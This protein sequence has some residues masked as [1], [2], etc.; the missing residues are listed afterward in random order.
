MIHGKLYPSREKSD[1]FRILTAENSQ[2]RLLTSK[3]NSP[4]KID[5]KLKTQLSAST[6]AR[7]K[8]LRETLKI[9]EQNKLNRVRQKIRIIDYSCGEDSQDF[10]FKRPLK[11]KSH[12]AK[13]PKSK[14]SPVKRTSSAGRLICRNPSENTIKAVDERYENILM[15][16]TTEEHRL[17]KFM[18]NQGLLTTAGT[19]NQKFFER[20]VNIIQEG[21]NQQN[22]RFNRFKR[23]A[24]TC[25]P[26]LLMRTMPIITKSQI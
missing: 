20:Y 8:L 2:D 26:S 18:R 12:L 10:K 14:F 25:P 3:K 13:E 1:L 17:I 7:T 4:V 22:Q 24:S 11:P 23:A 6:K 9:E 19:I 5:I 16:N 21:Y 15:V